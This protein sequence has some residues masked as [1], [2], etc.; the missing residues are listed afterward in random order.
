M[1]RITFTLFVGIM[2]VLLTAG[3]HAFTFSDNSLSHSREIAET[4]GNITDH[5]VDGRDV[6]FDTDNGF[7]IK[8]SISGASVIKIWIDPVGDFSRNNPSFAVIDKSGEAGNEREAENSGNDEVNIEETPNGYAI[9]TGELIVRVN[10]RPFRLSFYD[11]FQR[12]LLDDHQN[13]GFVVDQNEKI[14]Y[15]TLKNGENFFGLGEKGGPLN[16]RGHSF[17]MWNSDRPCYA[18]DEDPLYKSIPFF[19]SSFGYGIFFD[20]TYNTEFRF[21][22]ESEEHFSFRAPDGEMI[23]YFMYGPDYRKII[24]HYTELTGRPIMPPKWALGFSQSR[25]L[26][27][28]EAL[29]REIADGFRKRDIPNDIIYQDIGW[30]RY[31]QDFHWR[32]ENYDD[33]RGMLRDLEEEGFKVVVSQNPIV[34]QRNESQ[35]READSLGY[36]VRDARTGESYDMPW[37]WGGNCGV[38]DFTLPDVADWWG[39]LQ[40]K[41]ID[42]GIRGYWTDMGEPAW[43]NEEDTD[44]LHMQHHL[45][46]HDEIH[47]VY[48][49]T[50][51]KVVTEQFEKHNPNTRIFQMTRA[52]FAGLQRYTFGW[53]GD[54]GFGGDVLNGW[55]SLQGQIPMALSAGMGLIPFWSTDISGYC[56]DIHD[57]DAF[58]ELYTRWMQFGVFNPLSRAHH[59]GNNAVEPWLFGPE[60]EQISREAI[61]LKY[62]LFP[63]FYTY[64]RE[65]YDSGMPL[66]R[67]MI[68]EF[69]GESGLADVDQQF[70]L[71]S[72]LLVAP[73]VE[74][75]AARKRVYLPAGEWVDYSNPANTYSGR[76]W[77]DY[78]VDLSTIPMFVRKGSILPKMPVMQYIHEDPDYP[79]ILNVFPASDRRP[80]TFDVYEDDGETN[81]YKNNIYLNRRVI[82][83]RQMDHHD[84]RITHHTENGYDFKKRAYEVR[85]YLDDRPQRI[86]SQNGPIRERGRRSRDRI[87]WQWDEDERMCIILIPESGDDIALRIYTGE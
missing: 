43:S 44:R 67:A 19:M 36:F 70:M 11:N 33:P 9:Y 34:S 8:L 14:S 29:T 12:L 75:Y 69:P 45:G 16:R 60:V 4:P 5:E 17:R 42:D 25:G 2:F 20:N 76:Q 1:L 13:K 57:Y 22:S 6:F 24:E 35:W 41:P 55:P 7:R 38:V 21:G 72:E 81:D 78:P 37:P 71:G 51:S 62:Q 61:E 58:A 52:G 87:E 86:E 64:A 54:A 18:P 50:W 84:I 65:A 77:I 27:T 53:S 63:Y 23:Y 59:E 66:M 15:K 74:Q 28:N 79:L 32:P 26:L 47:N 10:A 39:E 73:V 80:V 82:A 85:I 56:G 31:L 48:G 3:A 68:L 40:Q 83:V 49:L 46:M 30:T